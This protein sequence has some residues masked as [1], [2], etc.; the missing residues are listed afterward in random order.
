MAAKAYREIILL[1]DLGNQLREPYSKYLQLGIFE[2]RIKFSSDI[3]RIFYFF[4]L[5]NEI[6]LINGFMKK[7]R[8]TPKKEL[9]LAI[10]YKK[11]YL[12]RNKNVEN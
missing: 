11:E 3:S 9:E 7:T 4:Y 12:E 1:R 8:K 2:L 6:I 5:K 10:K